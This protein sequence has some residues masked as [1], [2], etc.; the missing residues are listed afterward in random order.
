M[1]ARRKHSAVPKTTS[2]ASWTMQPA[3]GM[4]VLSLRKLTTMTGVTELEY[5]MSTKAK[6]LRKRYIGV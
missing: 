4:A 2:E 3:T 6:W 1:A 5:P